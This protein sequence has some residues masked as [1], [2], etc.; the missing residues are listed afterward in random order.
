MS[1]YK[2]Q[3]KKLSAS[4][5][6]LVLAYGMAII[7]TVITVRMGRAPEPNPD[8]MRCMKELTEVWYG[9]VALVTPAYFWKARSENRNKYSQLW[10]EKIAAKDG[11]EAAA[12]FAEI[13]T[14]GD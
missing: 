5:I 10:Y 14:K 1:R 3:S 7:L 8:I 11:W 9:L 6:I 13:I 4:K 12:R 2:H